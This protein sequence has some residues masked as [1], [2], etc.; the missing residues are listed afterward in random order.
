[1]KS[2]IASFALGLS[3]LTFLAALQT[4]AQ[5]QPAAEFFKDKQ[6]RFII[7]SA[8][9]GDYDQWGRLVIRYMSKHIPG[10]PNIVPNNMPG[11]GGIIAANYLYNTAPKDGTAFAVIG[12]N[13]PFQ[14]LTKAPNIRFDPLKFNWLGSP[15]LT[16]R[17]CA[18]TD[19]SPATTAAGVFERE[20]LMGGAGAGT[21]VSTVPVLLNRL[22]GTKFKLVEGYGSSTAVIL[23]MERNEVHGICQSLTSVERSKPGWI[24]SGKLKVLFNLERQP[25]KGLNAPSIHQFAKTDEQRQILSLFSSSV[26]FGRPFVAPPEVPADRVE[27]LRKAFVAALNEPELL[28]DAEKLGLDIALLEGEE[29]TGLIKDMMATPPELIAR[30]EALLK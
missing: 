8:P 2:R 23:A 4:G 20:I 25:V 11:G 1:M 27:I 30:M 28:K 26:E 24:A 17:V 29:L 18:V 22:L 12:R 21:A 14:A 16:S 13:L 6:I 10:N 3:S 9:G 15:E 7:H 5:A 19:Q